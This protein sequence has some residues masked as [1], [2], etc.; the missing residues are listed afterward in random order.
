MDK[1]TLENRRDF[2][3]TTNVLAFMQAAYGMFEQLAALGGDNYIVSGCTVT[4]SSVSAGY[5]VLKGILMPFT[6]GSI[7]TNVQ[8]VKTI[9]TIT[10]DTGTREQVSYHA[11][12]GTSAN[13]DENVPWVDISPMINL[14]QKV[15]AVA[16]HRLMTDAEGTKLAGISEDVNNYVHP[17]KHPMN[18]IDGL[19][20]ALADKVAAEAGKR[21]MTDAEGTKLAGIATN[22]N[23]YSHPALH[24]MD[25]I[26]GLPEALQGLASSTEWKGVVAKTAG[27]NSFNV[28]ARQ[29]GNVVTI[30]G[31]FATDGTD[32][33]LGTP[34]VIGTLPTEISAPNTNVYGVAASRTQEVTKLRIEAGKNLLTIIDDTVTE[35]EGYVFNLSYI[36]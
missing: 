2:P 8:I 24:P 6:G 21:L 26:D 23:N 31:I 4:G 3:M 28:K 1:L 10:V 34:F 17:D 25:K 5:M 14:Q 16:G 22:A 30:T 15:N 12:F 36:V 32:G 19:V 18:M 29:T 9:Q 13:P 11:K 7:T 33:S 27:I 20:E 35:V